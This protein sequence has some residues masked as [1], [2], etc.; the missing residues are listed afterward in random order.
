VDLTDATEVADLVQEDA[1]LPP[2]VVTTEL[3]EPAGLWLALRSSFAAA[4][5][6]GAVDSDSFVDY[7][8]AGFLP[9]CL[10]L[11][12]PLPIAS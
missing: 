4:A 5:N 1:G 9:P 8:L 2:I 3:V 11:L 6:S 7:N 10:L 12:L